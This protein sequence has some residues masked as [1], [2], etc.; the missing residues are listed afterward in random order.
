MSN[1]HGS[2]L[3]I[4]CFPEMSLDLAYSLTYPLQDE[5]G[6]NQVFKTAL[7]CSVDSKFKTMQ[8]S[9]SL[10]KSMPY[11]GQ[12]PNHDDYR[13]VLQINVLKP[14]Y[15]VGLSSSGS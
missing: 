15:P 1:F 5:R 3:Q 10:N 2:V 6:F 4:I 11:N 8:P 7:F 13:S 9:G 12:C 14:L